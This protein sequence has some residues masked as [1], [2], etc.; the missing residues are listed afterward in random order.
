MHG[1][2]D[3]WACCKGQSSQVSLSFDNLLRGHCIIWLGQAVAPNTYLS[4]E[5]CVPGICTRMQQQY[6]RLVRRRRMMK[7]T[8]PAAS[9]TSQEAVALKPKKCILFNHP[10]HGKGEV[11]SIQ[12]GMRER[13]SPRFTWGGL[14]ASLVSPI[15][16]SWSRASSASPN[17][18]SD[19]ARSRG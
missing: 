3:Q 7:V 12:Y 6:M 5:R 4:W 15:Q 13:P 16:A 11:L 2:C 19:V 18:I 17:S 8:V 1:T 9:A 10:K 14:D